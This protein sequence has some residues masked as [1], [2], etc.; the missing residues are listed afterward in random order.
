MKKLLLLS[1]IVFVAI[2]ALVRLR[3]A[4]DYKTFVSNIK[5]ET[6][7]KLTEKM[8]KRGI[9]TLKKDVDNGKVTY[10][11]VTEM[12]LPSNEYIIATVANENFIETY[13]YLKDKPIDETTSNID[14]FYNKILNVYLEKAKTNED[15]FRLVLDEFIEVFHRRYVTEISDFSVISNNPEFLKLTESEFIANK[16]HHDDA[17]DIFFRTVTLEGEEEIGAKIPSAT[18]GLVVAVGED[19]KGTGEEYISGGFS[20]SAGNAVIIY[21]SYTKCYYIYLHMYK[22]LVKKGQYVDIGEIIGIGGNTGINAR[23]ENRGRHV[24]FEI[25]DSLNKRNYT[26]D[27][28]RDLVFGL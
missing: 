2:F 28:L 19:W 11:V 15:S 24:H 22:P 3:Q 12:V 9:L 14:A 25:R 4:H 16:E 27:E 18:S 20:P 1:L 23:K 26:I 5:T 10:Q 6:Y 7:Q 13:E 21:N 17:I 8:I